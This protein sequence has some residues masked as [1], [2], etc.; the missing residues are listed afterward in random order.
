MRQFECTQYHFAIC[1]TSYGQMHGLRPRELMIL[2]ILMLGYSLLVS[3]LEQR[4]LLKHHDVQLEA[5][6]EGFVPV[7]A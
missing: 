2:R 6:I 1:L 4:C 7:A 3:S 5:H